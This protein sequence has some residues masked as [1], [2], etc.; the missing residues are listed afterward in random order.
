MEKILKLSDTATAEV[1]NAK[2]KE[3]LNIAIEKDWA[4]KRVF[5]YG[6]GVSIR[7][8]LKYDDY[9][10]Y[11]N[12]SKAI[13]RAEINGLIEIINAW[14]EQDNEGYVAVTLKGKIKAIPRRF[15]DD[16]LEMGAKLIVEGG[17]E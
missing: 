5:P 14:I 7:Q 13:I 2:V 11:T 3:V 1:V 15:L 10:K 16:Y 9:A 12:G 4:D 6:Y 17:E 8:L